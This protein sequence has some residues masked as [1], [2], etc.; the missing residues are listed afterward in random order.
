MFRFT[1]NFIFFA[2]NSRLF[3]FA[4]ARIFCKVRLITLAV[5]YIAIFSHDCKHYVIRSSYPE[6][7]LEKGVSKIYSKFTGEHRWLPVIWIKLQS[8][9]IEITLRHGCSPVNLLHI[10]RTAFTKNTSER[11]FLC[12][13]I[14]F[15]LFGLSGDIVFNPRPKPDPSQSFSIYHWDLN[16][17]SALNYSKISLLTA[18]ISIISTNFFRNALILNY[19]SETKYAVSFIF[20]ELLVNLKM[21]FKMTFWQT[22]K[23]I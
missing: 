6:V 18:Y 19:L 14:F 12:Y 8:N 22:W 9:L 1:V 20:I 7:F 17:M 21:N 23:W 4:I 13:G 11:L 10:F 16:S 2:I 5:N 3:L 15:R